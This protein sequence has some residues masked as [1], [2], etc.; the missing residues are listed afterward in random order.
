ML[1]LSFLSQAASCAESNPST[2]SKN[3]RPSWSSC[4]ELW[5][6]VVLQEAVHTFSPEF[7]VIPHDG[8]SVPVEAAPILVPD[9]LAVL[10]GGAS[11]IQNTVTQHLQP[12]A[13]QSGYTPA[14]SRVGSMRATLIS[15]SVVNDREGHPCFGIFL[16]TSTV[17]VSSSGMTALPGSAM[18]SNTS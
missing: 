17:Q 13:L 16:C 3:R 10:V 2:V 1:L 6:Q 11:V 15:G 9:A 7:A 18:L 5:V 12:T 14:H 4:A 8:P